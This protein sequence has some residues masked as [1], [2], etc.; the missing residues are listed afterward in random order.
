[1]TNIDTIKEIKISVQE[2]TFGM[3]ALPSDNDLEIKGII[4]GSKER[5]VGYI[6]GDEDK[7][8]RIRERIHQV[9][10]KDVDEVIDSIVKI[11]YFNDGRYNIIK[12][13]SF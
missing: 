13:V 4:E 11:L 6:I 10:H 2:I 9:M 7:T 1:M 3:E 12:E 8:K 5:F